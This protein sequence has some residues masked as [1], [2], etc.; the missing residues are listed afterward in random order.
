M[1]AYALVPPALFIAKPNVPV[2]LDLTQKE[3]VKLLA[4][5]VPNSK[6]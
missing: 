5:A 1:V 4:L 3:S 2:T 6:S